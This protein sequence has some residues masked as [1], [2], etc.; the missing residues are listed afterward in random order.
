MSD[1]DTDNESSSEIKI[2]TSLLHKCRTVDNPAETLLGPTANFD[3]GVRE[4]KIKYT[5]IRPMLT[6]E[7]SKS[8]CNMI[9]HCDAPFKD[10]RPEMCKTLQRIAVKAATSSEK[11]NVEHAKAVAGT[12]W[13]LDVK[14]ITFYQLT[15]P[16]KAV[17]IAKRAKV[18]IQEKLNSDPTLTAS[19]DVNVLI[20]L[21]DQAT[22][23]A[24]EEFNEARKQHDRATKQ[25]KVKEA[26][27]EMVLIQLQKDLDEP[28]HI[29]GE[30]TDGTKLYDTVMNERLTFTARVKAAKALKVWTN[31]LNKSAEDNLDDLVQEQSR[32]EALPAGT[33][34]G[35]KLVDEL[36]NA[37]AQIQKLRDANEQLKKKQKLEENK[38]KM[39]LRLKEFELEKERKKLAKLAADTSSPLRND[40]AV[41]EE[42]NPLVDEGEKED[43]LHEE[44]IDEMAFDERET[45]DKEKVMPPDGKRKQEQGFD[46]AA[47][48]A[49]WK[50][51][52]KNERKKYKKRYLKKNKKN[53]PTPTPKKKPKL[54]NDHTDG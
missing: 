7:E 24:T 23:A 37:Q 2:D 25:R 35:T 22:Q 48:T 44:E 31:Q 12:N 19:R 29:D 41:H 27:M 26:T 45:E 15:E 53:V 49:N 8:I 3:L 50:Y 14:C 40:A 11:Y 28:A 13:N 42:E 16:V 6:K 30:E 20:D 18:I 43:N 46:W 39:E 32:Q 4:D 17:S 34:E 21:F 38:A 10:Q 51:M 36:A 33:L 1:P 52:T 5:K 54:T 9:N 47:M